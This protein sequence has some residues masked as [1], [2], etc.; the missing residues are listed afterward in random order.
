MGDAAL[1]AGDGMSEWILVAVESPYSGDVERNTAYARAAMADC[2]RRGEAPFASHL[3]YTQP[4]VLKDD[5]PDERRRGI[6]AGFKWR[7]AAEKTVVY[8][9]LGITAGM[10]LGINHAA[11]I[12]QLVEMRSLPGWST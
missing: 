4:G 11:S 3:L 2:L 10:Q 12:G 5:D 8:A 6:E 1:E 7:L 9:D